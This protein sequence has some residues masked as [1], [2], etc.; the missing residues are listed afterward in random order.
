MALNIHVE[1]NFASWKAPTSNPARVG[2]IYSNNTPAETDAPAL[3]SSVSLS[4]SCGHFRWLRGH[5]NV[6]KNVQTSGKMNK[7]LPSAW[8][9]FFGEED[10]GKTER[11]RLFRFVFP[12]QKRNDQLV[13]LSWQPWLAMLVL[14]KFNSLP[15][16]VHRDVHLA[17]W[18][19]L[20]CLGI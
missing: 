6:T 16:I 1:S 9:F 3:I 11:F 13:Y 15:F 18:F 4:E 20:D 17:T 7:S 2:H 10:F 8:G 19:N 14:L 12:S 5:W